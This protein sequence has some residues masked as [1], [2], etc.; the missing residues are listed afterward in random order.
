TNATLTS[1]TITGTGSGTS[2]SGEGSKGVIVGSEDVDATGMVTMAKVDISNV[3]MGVE[4]KRGIL[5]MK[6]GSIGFTG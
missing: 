4:V 5:A 6:G 1:V 3:A 2:G